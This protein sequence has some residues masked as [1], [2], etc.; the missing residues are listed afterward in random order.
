MDSR[1]F[2]HQLG[3][4][5]AQD[6]VVLARDLNPHVEPPPRDRPFLVV[7]PPGEWMP[8]IVSHGALGPG[9]TEH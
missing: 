8:A 7:P 4:D 3:T 6:T 1:T 5:P 2:L 9:T